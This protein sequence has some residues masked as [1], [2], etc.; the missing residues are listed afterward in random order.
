MNNI[1]Q[2]E[3]PNKYTLKAVSSTMF[4]TNEEPVYITNSNHLI[5]NCWY[6]ISYIK[7]KVYDEQGLLLAEVIVFKSQDR[8]LFEQIETAIKEGKYDTEPFTRDITLHDKAIGMRIS[9]TP[10]PT[11][12][13]TLT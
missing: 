11:Y 12:H 7:V 3:I 10:L 5:H 8:I 13:V 2:P 1:T 4:G 9:L 6:E